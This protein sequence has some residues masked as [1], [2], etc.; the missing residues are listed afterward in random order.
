MKVKLNDEECVDLEKMELVKTEEYSGVSIYVTKNTRRFFKFY[1]A[2]TR[3]EHAEIEE[4]NYIFD[5]RDFVIKY[6][7]N[8]DEINDLIN[9]FNLGEQLTEVE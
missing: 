1:P 5:V 3:S 4:M 9:Y 8:V 2:G 7:D 6:C